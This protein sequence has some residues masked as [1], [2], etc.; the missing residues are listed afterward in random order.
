M[1]I[2]E[3][4]PNVAEVSGS[5][6]GAEFYRD[7]SPVLKWADETAGVKVTRGNGLIP[8]AWERDWCI[9]TGNMKP[10]NWQP[11]WPQAWIEYKGV[12]AWAQGHHMQMLCPTET[13]IPFLWRTNHIIDFWDIAKEISRAGHLQLTTYERTAIHI[14]NVIDDSIKAICGE[15]GVE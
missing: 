14:G 13:I 10:E 12:R 15:W 7:F 2:L 4:F 8:A 5:P 11:S 6:Q 3:T 1:E 9:S